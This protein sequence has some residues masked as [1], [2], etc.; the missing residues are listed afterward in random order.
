MSATKTR[1]PT[2]TEEPEIYTFH[3]I[4]YQFMRLLITPY[5]YLNGY[6][7]KKHKQRSKTCLIL[8]N[9]NTNWD[10]FLFGLC[11]HRHMYFVASEH[12]Y[13]LGFVSKIIKFLGAPISRKKGASGDETVEK[14]NEQLRK[15]HNV[16]MMAEG[17]RSFSGETGWISPRNAKIAKESGAGLITVTVHGGYFVNPRW[18]SEKRKGPTRGTVVREYTPEELAAMTEEEVTEAIRR[19][20][21]VNAYDDPAME[22][23][24]YTCSHPAEH[25][26]TALFLCPVCGSTSGLASEGARFFCRDCGLSL[27]FTPEG[28][29][30]ADRGEPPFTTVLD[31][32]R[33][34][35]GTLRARTEGAEDL[36]EPLFRDT[37]IRLGRVL[38]GRGTE[39]AAA[40]TLALYRDRLEVSGDC[41]LSFPVS[42]IEKISVALTD[43]MLFTADGCYYEIK[44]VRPFAAVKYLMAVRFLQKK[45]YV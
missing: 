1:R 16:C 32:D 28:R 12:I 33:W 2:E 26:E 19:D 5:F 35:Q 11:L 25:L 41:T 4:F 38:P 37:E 8:T 3:C 6:R 36:Q 30:A 43:T 31:W 21:Y 22:P 13:R 14:I 18:A 44:C 29:F 24:A 39:P 42:R 17:N 34:Q 15:G 40:G 45:E 7:W 9:H 10:F 20:L 27:R 23:A